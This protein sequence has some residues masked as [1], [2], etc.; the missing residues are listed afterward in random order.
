MYVLNGRD[1][2]NPLQI[3]KHKNEVQIPI[4]DKLFSLNS[5]KIF[6]NF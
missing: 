1:T 4:L 2:E 5:I 3:A 6:V